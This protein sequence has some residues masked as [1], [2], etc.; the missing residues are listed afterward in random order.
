MLQIGDEASKQGLVEE[1]GS[2]FLFEHYRAT[3]AR[4]YEDFTNTRHE[5]ILLMNYKKNNQ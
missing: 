3:L 4:L 2:F 1:G 5:A